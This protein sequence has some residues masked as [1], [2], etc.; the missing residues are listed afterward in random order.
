MS[1]SPRPLL[2]ALCLS[3]PIWGLILVFALLGL[4]SAGNQAPGEPIVFAGMLAP[5][6]GAIPIFRMSNQALVAKVVIFIGYYAACAITMFV[7][8]WAA[9]GVFGLAK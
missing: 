6:I 9:L 8:G 2:Y 4:S 3:F 7:V 5:F 1:L